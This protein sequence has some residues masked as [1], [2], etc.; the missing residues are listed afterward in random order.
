MLACTVTLYFTCESN[1]QRES[2]GLEFVVPY[3]ICR[4]LS[5]EEVLPTAERLNL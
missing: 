5:V 1:G 2:E 4:A 3:R